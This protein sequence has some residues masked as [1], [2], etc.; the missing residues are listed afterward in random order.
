MTNALKT[1]ISDKVVKLANEF[2]GVATVD[3]VKD[4]I[5]ENEISNIPDARTYLV[6]E[7]KK[8]LII[9]IVTDEIGDTIKSGNGN[10]LY[11]A[12]LARTLSPEMAVIFKE[13][14]VVQLT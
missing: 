3:L 6:Y 10:E 7:K 8:K 9:V 4:W 13:T 1:I 2:S 14:S 5:A 12:F 11:V